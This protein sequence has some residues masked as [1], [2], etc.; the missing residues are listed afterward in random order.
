VCPRALS[1]AST[2][3][4]SCSRSYASSTVF[5]NGPSSSC[6]ASHAEPRLNGFSL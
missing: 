3:L 6:R 5:M 4:R 2:A 1:N